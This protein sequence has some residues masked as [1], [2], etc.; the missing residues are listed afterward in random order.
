MRNL[1]RFGRTIRYAFLHQRIWLKKRGTR[2][3]YSL[4][5]ERKVTVLPFILWLLSFSL[6]GILYL[7][8]FPA[9]FRTPL[10]LS[11]RVLSVILIGLLSMMLAAMVNSRANRSERKSRDAMARRIAYRVSLGGASRPLEP[12]AL[13][14][15]PFDLPECLQRVRV[16]VTGADFS[17]DFGVAIGINE[18]NATLESVM[19]GAVGPYIPLVRF[20]G[21]P[22]MPFAIPV[23]AGII[24]E[25]QNWFESF[26]TLAQRASLIFLL[27]GDSASIIKELRYLLNEGMQDRVVMIMPPGDIYVGLEASEW[28][29]NVRSALEKYDVKLPRFISPGALFRLNASGEAASIHMPSDWSPDGLRGGLDDMGLL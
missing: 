16:P 24:D 25:V 4:S 3:W 17:D 28:W 20:G 9:V 29:R 14:L 19:Q 15:W 12:F 23:C 5:Y 8:L 2:V 13:Y 1:R 22:Y 18:G 21:E 26:K 7:H 11:L 10:N 6:I 27:P